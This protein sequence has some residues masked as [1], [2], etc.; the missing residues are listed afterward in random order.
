MTELAQVLAEALEPRPVSPEV[1]ARRQRLCAFLERAEPHVLDLTHP[2]ADTVRRLLGWDPQTKAAFVE[3]PLLCHSS[4]HAALNS[5]P[6]MMAF[7]WLLGRA[8]RLAEASHRVPAVHVRTQCTHHNFNDT[9]TKPHAWWHRSPTG[10]IA[11]TA[12]HS[13]RAGKHVS[14]LAR[15]RPDLS[16]VPMTELDA[17][18]VAVAGA[19]RDFGWFSVVYRVFLERHAGMHVPHRLIEVPIDL[20][21]R[22]TISELGLLPWFDLLDAAD[23]RLRRLQPDGTLAPLDRDQARAVADELAAAEDHWP[24]RALLAPNPINFAQFY[25]FGLSLMVGGRAMADYV[26]EMNVEIGKFAA[27]VPGW[28]CVPPAFL[29]FK[30]LPVA[31]VVGLAEEAEQCRA[32]YGFDTAL[33]L[34]V[35]AAGTGTAA[36][37]DTGLLGLDY[38]DLSS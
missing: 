14:V 6:P 34:V 15:P 4:P 29:P 23:L 20:L 10:E 21:N 11:K 7:P 27:S 22:F 26:P 18:A 1:R 28:D 19:T 9:F 17:E 32:R 36:A 38:A 24:D 25:L 30:R 35:S 8:A 33:S 5:F 12:V 3:S 13:R 2:H 16:E 31:E 37:L